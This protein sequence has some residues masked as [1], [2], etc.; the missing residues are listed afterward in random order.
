MGGGI[1]DARVSFRSALLRMARRTERDG[2]E[3]S[4]LPAIR[5]LAAPAPCP[6]PPAI[7]DRPACLHEISTS[8]PTPPPSCPPKRQGSGACNC[9][10]PLGFFS[11]VGMFVTWMPGARHHNP[12]RASGVVSS[13]PCRATNPAHAPS[14]R[15][16]EMRHGRKCAAVN[17]ENRGNFFKK[18][19]RKNTF[20]SLQL[21][22]ALNFSGT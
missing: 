13:I 6:G 15:N 8:I 14:M 4:G 7:S 9:P 11:P 3:R 12:V 2:V 1:T 18:L 19:R 16:R 10:T 20:F 21:C 22:C 5:V 17:G